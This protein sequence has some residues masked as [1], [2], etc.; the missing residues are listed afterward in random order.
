M[1]EGRASAQVD[2][3]EGLGRRDVVL[4]E[5]VLTVQVHQLAQRV[6]SL[7]RLRLYTSTAELELL[8][9]RVDKLGDRPRLELLLNVL[10]DLERLTVA[11]GLVNEV[12][13]DLLLDEGL[14]I[15]LGSS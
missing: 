8:Q 3:L 15:G 12:I 2:G 4:A 1:L 7:E 13:D 10:A 14:K 5:L 6:D 9:E 11:V